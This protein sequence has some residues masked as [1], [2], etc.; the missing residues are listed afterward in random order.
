[1]SK[2]ILKKIDARF[3]Y[4]WIIILKNKRSSI[5]RWRV[6]TLR[7]FFTFSVIFDVISSAVTV[8]VYLYI[9]N[10]QSYNSKVPVVC[11]NAFFFCW[12]AINE[13]YYYHYF[14]QEI[15]FI[16]L[17]RKRNI[18]VWTSK[19][20]TLF[21]SYEVSVQQTSKRMKSMNIHSLQKPR[22]IETSRPRCF[23]LKTN[24][25]MRFFNNT[26]QRD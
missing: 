12:E 13:L 3:W 24:C 6:S 20:R 22:N 11:Q 8:V 26:R 4:L 21:K 17:Y 9:I 16:F 10:K 1:M 7:Y 23:Y 5:F 25:L 18:C 2:V 19:V 14:F 15:F